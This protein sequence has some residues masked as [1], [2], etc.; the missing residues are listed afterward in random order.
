MLG[1]EVMLPKEHPLVPVDFTSRHGLR[2]L[3][4]VSGA[5][6]SRPET[7]AEAVKSFHVL[8]L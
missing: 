5:S 1:Q 4:K 2:S 7:T 8:D 6:S 3:P